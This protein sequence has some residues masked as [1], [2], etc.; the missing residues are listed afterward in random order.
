MKWWKI[1]SLRMRSLPLRRGAVSLVR[2]RTGGGS[3]GL[4]AGAREVDDRDPA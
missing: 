4:L 2:E 3:T 1:S